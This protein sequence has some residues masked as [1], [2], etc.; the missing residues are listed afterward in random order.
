MYAISMEISPS[1]AC[2]LKCS[3]L[4]NKRRSRCQAFHLTSQTE[5]T[6]MKTNKGKF[7]RISVESVAEQM[8]VLFIMTS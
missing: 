8:Y 7:F 6:L 5:C 1:F 2:L 3:I 4:N